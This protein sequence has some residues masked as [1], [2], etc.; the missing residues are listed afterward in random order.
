MQKGE[1]AIEKYFH[2]LCGGYFMN[3]SDQP[4]QYCSRLWRNEALQL[5]DQQIRD[6]VYA[7]ATL[8]LANDLDPKFSYQELKIRPTLEADLGK[9][10]T[11]N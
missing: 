2:K 7:Y 3:K 9:L 4:Q 11:G 1:Q 5:K 6:K 8:P 10:L